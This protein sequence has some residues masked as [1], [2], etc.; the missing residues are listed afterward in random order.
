MPT[1][2]PLQWETETNIVP[3]RRRKVKKVRVKKEKVVKEEKKDEVEEKEMNRSWGGPVLALPLIAPRPPHDS[4]TDAFR[5]VEGK[6]G[7]PSISKKGEFSA[8]ITDAPATAVPMAPTM[9]KGGGGFL[10]DATAKTDL[11]GKGGVTVKQDVRVDLVLKNKLPLKSWSPVAK[12]LPVDR[13]SDNSGG[14]TDY[15]ERP[16][17]VHIL[18]GRPILT[19]QNQEDT[20]TGLHSSTIV[21]TSTQT[22]TKTRRVI[23]T[24][25]K[26]ASK[27]GAET[28]GRSEVLAG[29][30]LVISKGV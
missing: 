5:D 1:S 12:R 6:M 2:E 24:T 8:S 15:G 16:T 23:I 19:E 4:F 25:P 21:A 3:P 27:V 29:G 10:S 14:K 9:T 17:G 28:T 7:L 30:G 22:T 13:T 18:G 26:P 20:V 11:Y